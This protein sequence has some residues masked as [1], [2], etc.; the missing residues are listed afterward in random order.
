MKTLVL[1]TAAFVILLGCSKRTSTDSDRSMRDDYQAKIEQIQVGTPE[2]TV[3]RL[4]DFAPEDG[5]AIGI[6]DWENT[7]D[8]NNVRACDYHIGYY[9]DPLRPVRLV[10][11][12]CYGEKVTRIS[13]Q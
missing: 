4:F 7:F 1:A 5:T 6:L 2:A 12:S 10:T 11:I 3:Q 9:D 13:E 8:E